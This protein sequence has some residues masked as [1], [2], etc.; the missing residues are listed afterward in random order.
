M[1]S[2]SE[3]FSYLCGQARCFVAEGRALPV[4]QRCLGLYTAAL[5]TGMWLAASGIWRR[6]LPAR[7]V[8]LGHVVMLVAAILGGLK[9]V[10]LGA[11]WRVLC[12]LWTGHVALLWLVGGVVH[13]RSLRSCEHGPQYGWRRRDEIQGFVFVLL[14]VVLAFAFER[15]MPLGW[16]VWTG[17]AIAGAVILL[18][19]SVAALVALSFWSAAGCLSVVRRA[20]RSVR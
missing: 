9:V 12:G 5:L 4:C 8:F 1:D 10:D 3:F 14:C 20:A 6:G 15:A 11:T 19:A 2:V 7:R 13:L 16:G 18:T 17:V